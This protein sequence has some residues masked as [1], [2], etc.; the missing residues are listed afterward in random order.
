MTRELLRSWTRDELELTWFSGQGAGGQHRNKHQNCV[1]LRDPETG[2]AAVGQEHRSRARNLRDALDR[3][4]AKLVAHHFEAR[5]PRAPETACV[6]TYNVC[7][8]RVVDHAS[9]ERWSHDAF[10]LGAAI[11]AR[12]AARAGGD[13]GARAGDDGA[14]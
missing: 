3:L 1:R 10:D 7:E 13:V 4:A 12:M 8:N 9:G 14:A 6:R 5:K 11:R 2:L